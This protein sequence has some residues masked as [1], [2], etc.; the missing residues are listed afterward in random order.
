MGSV[1][2]AAE[3]QGA[4]GSLAGWSVQG[5]MLVRAFRFDDFADAMIF[6]NQIAEQAETLDHHPNI[7]IYYNRV[8]LELISHDVGGITERDLRFARA[9]NAAGA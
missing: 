9:L 7:H 3:I 2:S 8:V 1:L 4:I 6:V 5:N